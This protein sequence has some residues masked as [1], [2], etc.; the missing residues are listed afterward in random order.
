MYGTDLGYY[1]ISSY[2]TYLDLNSEEKE[3]NTGY[4]SPYTDVS[5]VSRIEKS[6]LIKFIEADET[7]FSGVLRNFDLS[8]MFNEDEFTLFIPV[9]LVLEMFHK[10]AL[11]VHQFIKAHYLTFTLLPR[12][13]T[14][15]YR[16]QTGLNGFNFVIYP[17]NSQVKID[18][19]TQTI[20]ILKSER[21]GNGYVYYT[22]DAFDITQM[23]KEMTTSL[24]SF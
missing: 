3:F 1:T 13:L 14:S 9:K 8:K 16:V 21:V 15:T 4:V 23:Y 17:E 20:S 22:S 19:G 18:N 11:P 6:S 12:Q 2:K 5:I 7:E 10:S 24:N